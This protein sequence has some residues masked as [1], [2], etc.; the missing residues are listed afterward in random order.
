ME[1]LKN[2]HLPVKLYSSAPPRA[3]LVT[4]PVK[5]FIRLNIDQCSSSGRVTLFLTR[6]LTIIDFD[7][8]V[9]LEHFKTSLNYCSSGNGQ[10][11]VIPVVC[12]VPE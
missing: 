4:A 10:N 7:F 5:I 3:K 6:L 1:F 11:S 9:F 12:D 2:G 8:N